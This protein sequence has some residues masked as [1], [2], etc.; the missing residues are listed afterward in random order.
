MLQ[1]AKSS[2]VNVKSEVKSLKWSE[3]LSNVESSEVQ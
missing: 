1:W 2:E 3:K